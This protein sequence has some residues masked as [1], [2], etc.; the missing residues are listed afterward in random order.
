MRQAQELQAKLTKAQDELASLTVEASAGGGAVKAVV[1]GQ[2]KLQGIKID[3]AAVDPND[4]QMLEDLVMAAV[5]E[6]LA[7]SHELAS[8]HMSKLTGGFGLPGM[9]KR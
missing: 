8:A 9:G 6:A 5:N 4:V 1:T 7:K 3:P 2:Q